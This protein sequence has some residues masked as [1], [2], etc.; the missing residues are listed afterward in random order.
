VFKK[1]SYKRKNKYLL[2][3]IILF[4]LISYQLALK[5]TFQ[6]MH[7]VSEMETQAKAASDAPLKTEELKKQVKEIENIIGG[8]NMISENNQQLILGLVSSFCSKNNLVLQ[9]LPKTKSYNENNILVETNYLVVEGDFIKLLL[10]L[11]MLEHNKGAGRVSSSRFQS[12]KNLRTK[13]TELILT[14]YIQN[15]KNLAA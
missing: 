15:I 2:A 8:S 9:E 12:K 6:L 14:I 10:L 3:G 11:N 5:K 13:K 4:M 7:N 1:L